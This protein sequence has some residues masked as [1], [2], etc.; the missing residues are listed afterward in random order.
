VVP[1]GNAESAG[2]KVGDRIVATSATIGDQ[3]WRK[4]TVDGVSAAIKSRFIVSDNIVFRVQRTPAVPSD[5]SIS[6]RK[7]TTFEVELEK[8][9]GIGE[10]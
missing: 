7:V 4:N 1:G 2:I 8:P 10:W 9:L 6:G 5:D 3:M